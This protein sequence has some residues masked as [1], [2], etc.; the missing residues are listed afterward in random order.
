[1][2]KEIFGGYELIPY[3]EQ[4]TVEGSMI[5]KDGTLFYPTSRIKCLVYPAPALKK[6]IKN[7]QVEMKNIGLDLVFAERECYGMP[8]CKHSIDDI[9][10]RIIE[11]PEGY[12]NNI[13][14]AFSDKAGSGCVSTERCIYGDVRIIAK[15]DFIKHERGIRSWFNFQIGKGKKY[16][17]KLIPKGLSYYDIDDII[18]N[19]I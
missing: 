3:E 5:R 4:L 6:L 8:E 7:F 1:M 16:N 17:S 19:K 18:Q 12:S 14:A 9:K 13:I 10:E 2:K 11:V 15:S